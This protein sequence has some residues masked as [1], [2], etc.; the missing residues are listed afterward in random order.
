[1]TKPP[2]SNENA[3]NLDIINRHKNIFVLL[4]GTILTDT[5][6]LRDFSR[7]LGVLPTTAFTGKL[8]PKGVPSSGFRYMKGWGFSVANPGEGPGGPKPHP[9]FLDQTEARSAE[10]KFG[11]TSPLP[12]LFQGL[13]PALISLVVRVRDLV[14]VKNSICKGTVLHLGA[15]PPRIKLF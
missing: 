2:L 5:K 11:E 3:Y 6:S 10:K 12:C 1:M 15:E 13:D 14:S 9:L 8:H 7:V 4:N